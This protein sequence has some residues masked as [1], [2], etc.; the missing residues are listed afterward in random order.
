MPLAT[1][2]SA[3]V[4]ARLETRSVRLFITSS[5]CL[6]PEVDC[7]KAW[8]IARAKPLALTVRLL[9]RVCKPSMTPERSEPVLSTSLLALLKVSSVIGIPR[10]QIVERRAVERRAAAAGH[11]LDRA[12]EFAWC[13][14]PE[15]LW[16]E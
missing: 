10:H 9:V 16:R 1:G 4:T 6:P 3:C 11:G 14:P 15:M 8:L 5:S 13:H 7:V 2:L 12:R